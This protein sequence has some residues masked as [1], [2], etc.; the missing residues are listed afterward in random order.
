MPGISTSS[1]ITSGCADST[2]DRASAAPSAMPT[3]STPGIRSSAPEMS[4]RIV[5]ESSTT[6]TLVP[7]MA[8]PAPEFTRLLLI[9]RSLYDDQAA[10][11]SV[12]RSTSRSSARIRISR[13]SIVASPSRNCAAAASPMSGS[14]CMSSADTDTMSLTASTMTPCN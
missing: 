7:A 4:A 1:V 12:T 6:N 9:T 14:G 8:Q 3:T 5:S 2:S 11:A 13:S 10:S